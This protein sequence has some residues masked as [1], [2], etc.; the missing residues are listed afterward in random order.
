MKKMLALLL[1]ILL[2]LGA[3]AC[4]PAGQQAT[5]AP[6]PSG[7][8]VA[9][10]TQAPAATPTEAPAESGALRISALKGPTGMGMVALMGEEY[11]G[12]YEMCIRDRYSPASSGF[13]GPLEN[14][15][16]IGRLSYPQSIDR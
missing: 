13:H 12:Q 15:H 2:A 11:A 7:E 4:A 8:P 3:V 16:P 10:A 6:A 14:P 9:S 1:T 5:P